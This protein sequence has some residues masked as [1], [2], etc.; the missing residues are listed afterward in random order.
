MNFNPESPKMNAAIREDDVSAGPSGRFELTRIVAAPRA[1][2][3]EVWTTA[4]HFARWWGPKELKTIVR[5]FEFRPGG[6]VHYGMQLPDGNTMWG[7]LKFREIVAAEKLTY[8]T[9]FADEEGR[10]I[11]PP[12]AE[13]W[14]L[15]ILSSAVFADHPQGTLLTMESWPLDAGPEE[16]AV[17]IHGH[18]SMRQGTS[19]MLDQLDAYLTELAGNSVNTKGIG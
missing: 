13:T 18:D 12:F 4:E 16:L 9:S 8:V 3:F 19:G 7:V 15:E 17:F 2:V 10:P 14:P 11:R 1:R 5:S 6:A